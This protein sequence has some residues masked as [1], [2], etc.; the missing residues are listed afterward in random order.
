MT[1]QP[2]LVPVSDTAAPASQQERI[3]QEMFRAIERLGR[4]LER[5]ETERAS[6]SQVLAQIE[7]AAE[8]DEA[9]GKIYL[10]MLVQADRAPV[11]ASSRWQS[12]L[13]VASSVIALLA[14]GLV[15]YREPASAPQLTTAQL[16]ALDSL[17]E[18]QFARM[19][20]PSVDPANN[21]DISRFTQTATPPA[22]D[23]SEETKVEIAQ[24]EQQLTP[25]E[26][27]AIEPAAGDAEKPAGEILADE[28]PVD[29]KPAV[30][31]AK[32]ETPVETVAADKPLAQPA[33][34]SAPIPLAAAPTVEQKAIAAGE[35]AKNEAVAGIDRDQLLPKSYQTLE[36]RAFAGVA[37]AQHDLAALYVAG[38][39][40]VP[41]D[42]GRAVFW[43]TKSAEKGM[44]NAH[45]NLGVMYQQ[46]L[47]VPQDAA[48]ALSWYERAAQLGHPEAMYNLGIANI[49]GIGADRNI[50][51]GVAFFK[52]AA[53]AGVSQAAYNLGVLYES[54]F[55]GPADLTKA[56]EWYQTAANE[57]HAEAKKALARLSGPAA[58]PYLGDMDDVL[59]KHDETEYG[60]GDETTP[61]EEVAAVP[62]KK[63]LAPTAEQGD[64]LV[65]R[66]QEAL[67][68]RG[69]I[70]HT[71]VPGEMNVQTEAA[72]RSWQKSLGWNDDGLPSRE[73]LEKIEG[74]N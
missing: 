35:T 55:I 24:I 60:Q 23:A 64:D 58:Q 2:R 18:T 21:I 30:A 56:A 33:N 1:V 48:A 9:T 41:R 13:S 39:G 38:T 29:E 5:A 69:E 22:E 53:N 59:A 32:V 62:A 11:A 49:E 73:L 26:L 7:S 20:G 42:Y 6:F 16:A 45:Y 74:K 72:I 19:N 36:T 40:G 3:N 8:R 15:L 70:P 71:T 27:S 43:F 50:A 52:Q 66:I 4:K 14:V 25:E 68:Q 63:S 10:P 46:G 67:L 34:D 37:A 12:A 31:E 57:G 28:K 17:T 47:G 65:K 54:N 61:D 51:R 44:A